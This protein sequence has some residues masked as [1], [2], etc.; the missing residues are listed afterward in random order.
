MNTLDTKQDGIQI[1]KPS[2]IEQV[3]Q[4][5][6]DQ[7]WYGGNT[8][9]INPAGDQFLVTDGAGNTIPVNPGDQVIY[10]D[11]TGTG[12]GI[13]QQI[14]QQDQYDPLDAAKM[15]KA[16]MDHL[17]Q[18]KH[19]PTFIDPNGNFQFTVSD[20]LKDF[21]KETEAA[22]EEKAR[23][24]ARPDDTPENAKIKMQEFDKILEDMPKPGTKKTRRRR[25]ARTKAEDMNDAM[26][27]VWQEKYAN[28]FIEKNKEQIYDQK[29]MNEL[30]VFGPGSGPINK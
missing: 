3:M 26:K 7:I 13:I 24:A 23:E 22:E 15:Q 1:P 25:K 11:N 28:L 21:L 2:S 19:A 8:P 9:V 5:L 29:L 16:W 10:T 14:Q 17:Q 4:K 30:Q 20:E 27:K 12:G 6:E 18:Q